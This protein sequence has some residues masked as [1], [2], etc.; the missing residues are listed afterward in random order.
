MPIERAEPAMVLTA[1]SRLAAVR[2]LTLIFAISSS[3]ARVS[4]PTFRRGRDEPRSIFAAFF[5]AVA[6][7]S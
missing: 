7:G 4:L 2:S 1:A 5:R 3:C 6:G